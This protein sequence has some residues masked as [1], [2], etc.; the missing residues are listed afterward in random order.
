L[1]LGTSSSGGWE[2]RCPGGCPGGELITAA[3]DAKKGSILSSSQWHK[4]Y[5]AKVAAP[6]NVLFELLSDMPNYRRWLPESEA[7]SHTTDVDPYPV[8]LGSKYHDGRPDEPGKDWWGT[9]IGFQRPGSIDF[10]QTIPVTQLKATVDVRIHYSLESEDGGTRV[11]RWQVM[12]VYMPTIVRPLRSVII[13]KFDQEIARTMAAVK[14]FAE[15]HA[16]DRAGD[17]THRGRSVE[18]ASS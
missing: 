3:N 9:V 10:H 8:E 6:R 7:F 18:H 12:D 4:F 15:S 5:S 11:S 16:A 17:Q 13:S 14:E 1:S 2:P